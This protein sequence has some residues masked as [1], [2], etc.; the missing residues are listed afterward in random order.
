MS[1]KDLPLFLVCLIFKLKINKNLFSLPFVSLLYLAFSSHLAEPPLFLQHRIKAFFTFARQLVKAASSSPAE[2][3]HSL[4]ECEY[5]VK[6]ESSAF[7][8]LDWGFFAVFSVTGEP[9]KLVVVKIK[10]T[11]TKIRKTILKPL[12]IFF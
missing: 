10:I 3:L 2:S 5:S 4:A 9:A 6:Q 1:L 12:F 8:V 7:S 11:D